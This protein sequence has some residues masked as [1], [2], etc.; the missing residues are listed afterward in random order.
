MRFLLDAQLPA[1]LA[2]HLRALGHDA[3]HVASI[4]D[5][6]SASDATIARLADDGERIV[7]SKD[8]DFVNTHRVSGSPASLL[9]VK[10]GNSSNTQLIA[11]FEQRLDDLAAAFA[12][13]SHVE[14]HWAVLVVHSRRAD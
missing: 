5:G 8:A 4:P 6:L 1:R 11:L 12:H 10:T 13:A 3:V 14:L 9:T 2:E 7:V